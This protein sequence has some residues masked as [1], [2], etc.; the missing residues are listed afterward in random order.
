MIR[1]AS[2]KDLERINEL[3]LLAVKNFSQTYNIKDYLNSDKYIII[4]NEDNNYVNGF[5]LLLKNL[6][7]YELEVI[8]VD[9]K[10]QNQGIATK[11]MNYVGKEYCKKDD[12]IL[13]EVAEDNSKAFKLYQKLDYEII[14]RRKKYYGNVDAY[15]MKK[16]IK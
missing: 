13:L 14:N 2:N 15:V 3:G 12:V 7:I 4:V 6:E 10:F 11:M 16:V 9:P 5:I 8:A 1:N